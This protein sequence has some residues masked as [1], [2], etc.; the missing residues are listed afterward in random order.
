MTTF[1]CVGVRP[2]ARSRSG[3]I[4]DI[5]N[6]PYVCPISGCLT[7]GLSQGTVRGGSMIDLLVPL[8]DV[9]AGE[10]QPL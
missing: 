9:Q 1:K 8:K 10:S 6:D 7:V 2:E 5:L 4:K 3:S